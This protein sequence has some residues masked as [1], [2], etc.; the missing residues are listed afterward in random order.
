MNFKIK[1]YNFPY[2]AGFSS[3]IFYPKN[4]EELKILL[5]KNFTIIGNLRS[6][7][8]TC[9]GSGKY[10]S[11]SQFNK[12]LSLDKKNKIIEIESGASLKQMNDFIFEKGFILSCMPGCK[13]VSI[14]GMISNNISGKL[15]FKNKMRNYVISLKIINN[16][17]KL[18]ECSNTKNKKLFNLTIGG[19]GRTG[20]IISAKLKLEKLNSSQIRQNVKE[21]TSYND[22]FHVVAKI[23]NHKY[24]VC[25][26]DFT[27]KNFEGLVFL[28]S[29]LH[30]KK[31]NYSYIDLKFPRII[32]AFISLFVSKK[33]TTIIINFIFKLKNRYN[34]YQILNLNSFFF[35]QNKILNWNEFFKPK[36]FFQFQIY[37]ETNKLQSIIQNIKK[38]MDLHNL[39]SNFAII[40]FN[41][42][43]NNEIEKLSLSLDFPI[44]D[45]DKKIR[46]FI[47]KLALK[48]DLD[49]E[50]SKDIVLDQINSK[51]LKNN[52]IFQ[53]KN[54]KYFN[55]NFKSNIFKRL[56]F[57]D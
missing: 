47:N 51:T 22:F 35:P 45:N 21:F 13:Y 44:D 31:K 6:Y 9:I 32:I 11:L 42:Y 16:K 10:L 37:F 7:G 1:K 50:L 23:K 24:G 27:K 20:P 56:N 19:K 54:N 57:N 39:F 12:I 48:Y 49:V 26:I 8:D 43:K 14:G 53:K 18:I 46:K 36:G 29:H 4:I 25:W 3:K 33:F 17:N 52:E 15:L 30:N 41:G 2:T 5:T 28:G 40:K 34:N 38:D 55:S